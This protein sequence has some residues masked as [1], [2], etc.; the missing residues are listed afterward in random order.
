ML[1]VAILNDQPVLNNYF[2]ITSISYIPGESVIINFQ[3]IEPEVDI[4]FIPGTAATCTVTF[5]LSDGTSLVKAASMLF[6]PDD[7]SLWTV[8][9]ST[10]ESA[11]VIGTNFLAT[12]DVL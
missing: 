8:S 5:K 10:T 1:S 12:L 7:R 9:L 3:F 6:N 2:T 11:Q 4:R